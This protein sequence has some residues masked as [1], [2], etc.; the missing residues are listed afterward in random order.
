MCEHEELTDR[1][2][3]DGNGYTACNHCGEIWHNHDSIYSEND[4]S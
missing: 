3:I 4:D 2:D 1:C